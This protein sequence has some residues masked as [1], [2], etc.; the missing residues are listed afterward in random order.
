MGLHHAILGIRSL[1]A[2]ETTIL[3]AV[4][5]KTAF[6]QVPERTVSLAVQTQI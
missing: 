6:F 5:V 1:A 2:V 3:R 4:M